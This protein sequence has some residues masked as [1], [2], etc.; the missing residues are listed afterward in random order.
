M[1]A[2]CPEASKVNTPHSLR[3]SYGSWLVKAGTNIFEIQ[4]LM[5]HSSPMI[6]AKHYA[7]LQANELHAYVNRL[8]L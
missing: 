1:Q 6:T 2:D 5:G 8:S 3:A 4:K 7:R